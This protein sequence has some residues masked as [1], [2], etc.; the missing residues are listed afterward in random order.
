MHADLD[1]LLIAI[2]CTADDL[3]RRFLAE[4]DACEY[5]YC[6]SHSRFSWGMRLHGAFAPDGTPRAL[7]LQP[8][9]PPEREVALELLARALR[10][11]EAVVCDKG[12]G[13]RDFERC[14]W[15]NFWLGRPSR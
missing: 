14:V 2:S 3:L 9:D 4:A 1:L 10:G 11:G 13:S 15:V 5:G 7:S 12:Y 8:V 6:R